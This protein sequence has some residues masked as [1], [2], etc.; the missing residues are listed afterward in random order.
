[1]NFS[2]FFSIFF[3]PRDCTMPQP[4]KL[5]VLTLCLVTIILEI[6]LPMTSFSGLGLVAPPSKETP[7][8][9]TISSETISEQAT[10]TEESQVKIVTTTRRAETSGTN[11]APAPSETSRQVILPTGIFITEETTESAPLVTDP[12]TKHTGVPVDTT[13]GPVEVIDAATQATEP[14]TDVTPVDHTTTTADITTN[15]KTEEITPEAATE[16]TIKTEETSTETTE[17][18]TERTTVPS[19]LLTTTRN[20]EISSK[21]SGT[22]TDGTTSDMITS[23]TATTTMS[24]YPPCVPHDGPRVANPYCSC[25][26]TTY[27]QH[28]V[29]SAPLIVGQ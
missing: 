20:G 17:R 26:T 11:I 19:T 6:S 21:S 27:G 28:L 25:E 5:R 16:G 23:T 3:T 15:A 12:I 7:F 2:N 22:N 18:T 9:E 29:A 10:H 13:T 4:W 24:T 14:T 1:M 8:P